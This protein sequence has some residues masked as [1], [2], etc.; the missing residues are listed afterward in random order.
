[1]GGVNPPMISYNGG[2][3]QQ[4]IL[5]YVCTV[6]IM[7]GAKQHF[8]GTMSRTAWQPFWEHFQAVVGNTRNT[9]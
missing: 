5:K 2:V 1:M 8:D 9:W 4:L 3:K 7:G 6:P